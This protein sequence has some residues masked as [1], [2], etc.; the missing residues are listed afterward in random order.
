VAGVPS[1]F[2]DVFDEDERG[3]L[4]PPE[5]RIWRHPSEVN[6]G[7][8]PVAA[9][10]QAARERWISSTP[11]RAG[12]WSAGVVG[13]VLA[14]GVVLV[15]MHMTTWMGTGSHPSHPETDRL[16]L[17]TTTLASQSTAVSAIVA[18]GLTF[19][20]VS[21]PQGSKVY[22]DGVIIGSVGD[23]P[24]RM[25][26]VPAGL[27]TGSSAI[28][29][30]TFDRQ[31]FAGELVGS[32]P[33]SGLAVVSILDSDSIHQLAYSTSSTLQPGAWV[34]AAWATPTDAL[35]SMG[36]V[37]SLRQMSAVD[38][39]DKLLLSV[40]LEMPNLTTAPSGM[41]LV[42]GEGQ[43]LGIVTHRKGDRV[44]DVP[45]PFAE[46]VGMDIAENGKFVHGWLGISA[47]SA[48]LGTK[49]TGSL[50]TSPMPAGVEVVSV[51]DDSSGAVAG[52][53]PGDVIEA[54]D[55]RPVHSML[56]LGAD[57]LVLPP[58]SAVQLTVGSGS[59]V[60]TVRATLQPA[61]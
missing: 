61:A 60:R 57:L 15:G 48:S 38:S 12:A 41:A 58:R 49:I 51:P 39:S 16:V 42:N 33:G 45:A 22:G 44:T 23:P 36:T 3:R 40:D 6:L 53:K 1:E 5:D 8:N 2:D 24:R 34:A 54:I 43:L 50:G 9:E 25:I 19:I 30:T 11:S 31:V 18:R 27:V 26:L 32:D 56:E 35:L 20:A 55:G 10:A 29:V 37:K 4:L 7:A 46:L 14:T 21:R 28:E 13:A 47:R 17:T 52:L 59:T